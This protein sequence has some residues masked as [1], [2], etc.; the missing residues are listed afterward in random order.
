MRVVDSLFFAVVVPLKR[1]QVVPLMV[2]IITSSLLSRIHVYEL[3]VIAI[4][5]FQFS[6]VFFFF[7]SCIHCDFTIMQFIHSV[8]IS[9]PTVC[10][11]FVLITLTDIK[12]V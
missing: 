7:S 12:V 6:P 9:S 5:V 10:V 4:V 3:A 2:Y 8:N 1:F 11:H